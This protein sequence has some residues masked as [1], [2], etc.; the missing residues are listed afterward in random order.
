MLKSPELQKSKK[1]NK[2]ESELEFTNQA[3]ME[4]MKRSS[5]KSQEWVEKYAKDFRDLYEK[6]KEQFSEI[7]DRDPEEL[8]VLLN[9]IL[10]S[11]Q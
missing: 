1:E 10:T 8:Y 11:K 3:Q 2:G 5:L 9:F 7:Y 4:L 6:N